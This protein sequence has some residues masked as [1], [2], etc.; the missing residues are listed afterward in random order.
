MGEHF[1]AESGHGLEDTLKNRYRLRGIERAADEQR[2]FLRFREFVMGLD[3][4]DDSP[5]G[6]RVKP[7]QRGRDRQPLRRPRKVDGDE[8]DAVIALSLWERVG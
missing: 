2:L 1:D 7:F 5:P 4:G 8:V 6:I 3:E